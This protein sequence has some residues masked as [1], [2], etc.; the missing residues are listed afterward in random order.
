MGVSLNDLKDVPYGKSAFVKLK[1]DY[2]VV[3]ASG[4]AHRLKK[5]KTYHFSKRPDNAVDKKRGITHYWCGDIYAV[6]K[7]PRL[8]EID[9]AV[10]RA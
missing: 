9:M 1:K 6:I 10:R 5:G 8:G 4:K 3:S 2:T 7:V